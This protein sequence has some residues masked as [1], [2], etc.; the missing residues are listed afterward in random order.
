MFELG[1]DRG[2]NGAGAG[3]VPADVGEQR[4]VAGLAEFD[5]D[6]APL[7]DHRVAGQ[8]VGVHG[9][10]GQNRENPAVLGQQPLHAARDPHVDHA[11]QRAPE[12][13]PDDEITQLLRD[14][15]LAPGQGQL[16]TRIAIGKLQLPAR[17]DR[18][19]PATQCHPVAHEV[20]FGRVVVG[21]LE[22]ER[23]LLGDAIHGR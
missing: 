18:A 12:P 21:A 13:D 1:Q 17:V 2:G 15:A 11:L 5:L 19:A 16:H 4:L 6:L 8:R 10:I 20:E 23:V 9:V 22:F 3:Q 14:G 7:A